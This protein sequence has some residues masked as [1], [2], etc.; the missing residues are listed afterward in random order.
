M[1]TLSTIGNYI[2]TGLTSESQNRTDDT[3]VLSYPIGIASTAANYYQ[4]VAKELDE[5]LIAAIQSQVDLINQKKSEIVGL[6][7]LALGAFVP[8]LCLPN[9]SL[10]SDTGDI[11]TNIDSDRDV[12]PANAG[13][14]GTPTP[15][16]AYGNV[17]GDF[18]RIQR[19]PRLERREAPDDNPLENL[20]FPILTTGNSGQGKKNALFKNSKWNDEYVTYYVS[21]DEGNWS[22]EGWDGGDTLGRY[23]EITGPGTGVITIFGSVDDVNGIFT[24]NPEYGSVLSTFTGI[25]TGSWDVDGPT[26]PANV[27]WDPSTNQLTPTIIFSPIVG[28]SGVLS[29]AST[30]SCSTLASQ[31]DALEAEITGLRSGIGTWFDGANATKQRKH[32]QQLRIWSYE[33]IKI[34]ND[35]EQVGITTAIDA[36]EVVDPQLPDYPGSTIDTEKITIDSTNV[37]IDLN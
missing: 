30:Q 23:Y 10:A 14:G 28:G 5:E 4:I 37:T 24:P 11:N 8:G 22:T 1:S 25:Q 17:R 15:A 31:I 7:Q 21:D 35:E 29:I 26:A 16:I 19:Y 12:I 36:T 6:C 9:C 3:N 33:R 20:K 18:I 2:V 32:S 34:R 27:S 13:V